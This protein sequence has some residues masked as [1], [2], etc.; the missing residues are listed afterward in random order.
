MKVLP[1]GKYAVLKSDITDQLK[2][3]HT[4]IAIDRCL[5]ATITR[6]K[7][8]SKMGYLDY[9]LVTNDDLHLLSCKKMPFHIG[10]HYNF[11]LE[12]GQ[13]GEGIQSFIGQVRGN[14]VGTTFNMYTTLSDQD[15]SKATELEATIYYNPEWYCCEVK[16]RMIQVYVKNKSFKYHELD[17]FQDKKDLKEL[18]D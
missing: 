13:F 10:S 15:T 7:G 3:L 14:F 16:A 1:H 4:P 17:G 2:F 12:K 8:C 5:E 11:S 9:D 18:Y 6:N